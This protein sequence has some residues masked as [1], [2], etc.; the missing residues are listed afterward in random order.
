M[1]GPCAA[2]LAVAVELLYF[3]VGWYFP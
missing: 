2:Y 3:L 1:N